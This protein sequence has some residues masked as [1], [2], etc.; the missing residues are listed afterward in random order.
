M[1][2]ARKYNPGAPPWHMKAMVMTPWPGIGAV[3][4]SHTACG[5][6]G[7]AEQGQFPNWNP[8]FHPG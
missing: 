8:N 2:S 6:V 4:G 3:Q 5:S 7:V 1:D